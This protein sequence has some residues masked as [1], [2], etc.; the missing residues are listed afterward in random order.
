MSK[1]SLYL[2]VSFLIPHG[3]H[4]GVKVLKNLKCSLTKVKFEDQNS[5]SDLA[6]KIIDRKRNTKDEKLIEM[7]KGLCHPNIVP[8][9]SMFQNGF[10]LFIFLQWM[11][12]GN[13][14]EFIRKNGAV[15]EM[16]AKKWILQIIS[17]LK[18]LHDQ[19]IAYC[20]L[21][22]TSI[23][24]TKDDNVK[25]SG[26]SC[27]SSNN[28]KKSKTAAFYNPPEVNSLLPHNA[29]KADIFSLGVIL[30]IMVNNMIPFVA[31]NVTQLIDDQYNRRYRIRTSILQK[32]SIDCQVALHV[33]LEPQTN[34][35]W[36]ID[37]LY[38]LKWLNLIQ[39]SR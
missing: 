6:C 34:L 7:L 31:S 35:R 22:C 8:I 27:L 33:M 2:D 15:E 1:S 29:I 23:M 13:L 21:S 38:N 4:F 25:I 10:L 12:E 14:L 3:Y 36:P 28:V 18:F 16:K 30:F 39:K 26:L 19:K 24:M 17:A 9:H 5:C 11:D 20:N 37:K 32:L